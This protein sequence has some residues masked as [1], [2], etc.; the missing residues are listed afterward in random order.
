MRGVINTNAFQVHCHCR[1]VPQDSVLLNPLSLDGR[2]IKGE[3]DSVDDRGNLYHG[4]YFDMGCCAACPRRDGI[5]MTGGI[6]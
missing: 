5:E 6:A 2:G 1:G 4:L 3:G